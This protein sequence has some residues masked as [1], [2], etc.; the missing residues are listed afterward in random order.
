VGGHD[1]VFLTLA[2]DGGIVTVGEG[3]GGDDD[4]LVSDGVGGLAVCRLKKEDW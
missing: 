1:D 2:G 3:V 4:D